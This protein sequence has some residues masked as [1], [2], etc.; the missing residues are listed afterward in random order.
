M[1]DTVMSDMN[2]VLKLLVCIVQTVKYGVDQIVT[3]NNDVVSF[4]VK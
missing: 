2:D 4:C 3:V 1:Y